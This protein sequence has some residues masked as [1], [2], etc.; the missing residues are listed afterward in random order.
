MKSIRKISTLLSMGLAFLLMAALFFLMAAP[1][2][3]QLDP[4]K[5]NILSRLSDLTGG[6]I[7]YQSIRI[8]YLPRPEVVFRKAALNW[9]HRFEI[10][11]EEL[12]AFP[13][14][15][16][17][18][19]GQ[20]ELSEIV[21]Q[22]PQIRLR[23]PKR[24]STG[25]AAAARWPSVE[26][27]HQQ[28]IALASHPL[29]QKTG[30]RY[31]MFDG[32]LTLIHAVDDSRLRFNKIQAQIQR[33][34]ERLALQLQCTSNLWT[35][36]QVNGQIETSGELAAVHLTL[37]QFQPHQAPAFFLPATLPPVVDSRFDGSAR[38]QLS[39]RVLQADLHCRR[40]QLIFRT[41]AGLAVFRGPGFRGTVTAQPHTTILTV[42]RMQFEEPSLEVSGTLF[43]DRRLPEIR[44]DLSGTG[45]QVAPLR[46]RLL[47]V[48]GHHRSVR[49][50]FRVLTGGHVPLVT[51][52]VRGKS[53][54]ELVRIENFTVRGSLVKGRLHI[55]GIDLDLE[56]VKGE[57]A[58]DKGL[59]K[60]RELQAQMAQSI[61]YDG[62]LTLGL[63]GRNA[64]FHLNIE[65]LA[66]MQQ[67]VPVLMRV[68]RNP[69]FQSELRRVARITGK[70]R[71]RLAI[72]DRLSSLAV[73]ARVSFADLQAVYAPLP[74]PVAI[75]GGAYHLSRN[76]L[77]FSNLQA[78]VGEAQFHNISGDIHWAPTKRI[79]IA[80]EEAEVGI[81]DFWRWLNGFPHP[82][83]ELNDIEVSSG[84]ARLSNIYIDGPAEDNGNW[85]Y[86]LSVALTDT[87]LQPMQQS[88]AIWISQGW[89]TVRNPGKGTTGITVK[90]SRIRWADSWMEVAGVG[91]LDGGFRPPSGNGSH[92]PE[93][94]PARHVERAL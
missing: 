61:G 23:L 58:I 73:D 88:E 43:Q 33:N 63:Q 14:V 20:I 8:D 35:H 45:V 77:S 42:H 22:Q 28:V 53:F 19:T 79:R 47:D 71:G 51:I 80:A 93:A 39:P 84:R 11:L 46:E 41:G 87:H 24:Q 25:P 68:V 38:L 85:R 6:Q 92:R 17:L 75:T 27:L 31:R 69:T 62:E 65:T 15:L 10:S 56:A 67:L 40:H 82:Y 26:V 55:P 94:H 59:L 86:E 76:G 66:D 60:A 7:Q 16:P 50:L 30:L 13:A 9:P 91:D 37:K 32:S 89:F 72:G 34:D 54:A 48:A 36:L 49:H 44:L 2:L 3:L 83:P 90:P 64:P 5:Q 52:H 1:H 74:H 81:A 4:I 12:R 78:V 70:A 18:L 57:A 21:L 29:F